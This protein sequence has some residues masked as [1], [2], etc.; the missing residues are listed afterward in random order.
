MKKFE[1]N[2]LQYKVGGLLYMPANQ[3]NI[4]KKIREGSINFLT[5]VAFC[6]EDSI[7]DNFLNEAENFLQ[8]TLSELKNFHEGGGKLPLIFVRIR[9]AEHL[10]NFYEKISDFKKIITGFIFPKFDLSNAENFLKTFDTVNQEKNFFFMPTFE[11]ES[12]ANS[13]SRRKNLVE[14]KNILD[15]EKNFLLNIRVGVNDFCNLYGLRREKNQTVYEIGIVRDILIDILNIFSK[16]YIVAGSVFNFFG[17][18]FEETFQREIFLDK[19]NGFIG[20]SAIHPAQLKFIF[21]SLKVSKND[22]ADAN[23]ILNEKNF[24][25][26]KSAD[27]SRMNEIKCHTNW[28]KKI[29]IFSE[30]YGVRDEKL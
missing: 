8:K 26:M 6:L 16:N 22:L 15:S 2:I 20:K 17:G 27:G 4:S 11:T 29:K 18:N 12:I 13:F 1:K 3:K 23:L 24:G 25:V 19:T 14:L 7:H 5:S 10:K 9:S 21:E 28:A 30:I